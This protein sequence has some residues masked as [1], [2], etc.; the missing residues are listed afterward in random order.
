M[1]NFKMNYFELFQIEQRYDVD[2]AKLQTQY[3]ALQAKYHPDIPGADA[4]SLDLS[5]QLNEGYRILKDDYLRAEYYLRLKGVEFD[6]RL[7]KNRLSE[8]E[9][10][11]IMEQLEELEELEDYGLLSAM[12]DSKLAE[13]KAMIINLTKCFIQNKLDQALDITIR[14]KYLTNLVG[15]IKSKI[16]N[17]NN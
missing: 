15:N 3:F 10:A 17:A 1:D 9:L 14:L 13:K 2:L 4:Q 16:K 12:H 7:L 6:D 8:E 11:T 5:M